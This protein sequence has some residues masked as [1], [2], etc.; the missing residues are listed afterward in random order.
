MDD[1]PE[2]PCGVYIREVPPPLVV[3]CNLIPIDANNSEAIFNTVAG[4][5]M[6][7]TERVP[8]GL[9]ENRK[10]IPVPA[11]IAAA[12]QN[13][14]QSRNRLVCTVLQGQ[15]QPFGIVAVLEFVWGI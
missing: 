8:I 5:V 11:A 13:R 7:R 2:T 14:L 12:S 9:E 1:D 6:L 15:S 4:S 10:M 3:T